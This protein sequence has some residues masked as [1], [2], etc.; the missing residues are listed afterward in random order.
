MREIVMDIETLS[1]RKNALVV[2]V[3]LVAFDDDY[4]EFH[5]VFGQRLDMEEQQ[6]KGRSIDMDT[7]SWWMKQSEAARRWNFEGH[8]VSV[9]NALADISAFI[10][11]TKGGQTSI[12]IWA[13]PPTFDCIIM[14]SL[15]NDFGFSRPWD[16]RIENDLRS[17][18]KFA[19]V[20]KGWL[21]P[22]QVVEH[23]PTDD[24]LWEMDMLREARRIRSLG[25]TR[26]LNFKDHADYAQ[27]RDALLAEGR[28]I[29]KEVHSQG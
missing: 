22:R 11:K 3:G 14:E 20:P 7:V 4:P 1:T 15:F 18:T 12:D 27:P 5:E 28:V 10:F 2:S 9:T 29:G 24:C 13:N 17:V 16:F 26:G 6:R 8:R 21:S 25:I 19:G 23:I